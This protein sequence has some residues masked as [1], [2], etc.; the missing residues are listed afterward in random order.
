VRPAAALSAHPVTAPAAAP[1]VVTGLPAAAPVVPRLAV[2][3]VAVPVPPA[4]RVRLGRAGRPVPAAR[5]VPVVPRVLTVSRVLVV[6]RGIHVTPHPGAHRLL[7]RTIHRAMAVLSAPS[8]VTGP[9]GPSVDP[10]RN[11]GRVPA[12]RGQLG[13][14]RPADGQPVPPGPQAVLAPLTVVLPAVVRAGVMTSRSGQ[15]AASARPVPM[16]G[17]LGVRRRPAGLRRPAGRGLP[18]RVPD[19]RVAPGSMRIGPRPR[20]RPR[21]AAIVRLTPSAA[22]ALTVRAGGLAG[23]PALAGRHPARLGRR[24]KAVTAATARLMVAHPTTAPALAP[25]PIVRPGIARPRT[26]PRGMAGRRVRG[27]TAPRRAMGRADPGLVTM[28]V[29]G[30]RAVTG[31]SAAVAGAAVRRGALGRGALGR[32]MARPA[33]AVRGPRAGRTVRAAPPASEERPVPAAR[34]VPEERRV[35]VVTRPTGVTRNGAIHPGVSLAIEVRGWT[36][37]PSLARPCPTRSA[38]TSSTRLPVAS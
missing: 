3:A 32:E 19:A 37:R 2:A 15:T 22:T 8:E 33:V 27:G 34:Q 12:R 10:A 24:G 29:P 13:P 23:R 18:V 6:R 25:R 11:S 16:A 35:P 26:K 17:R 5:L 7:P 1:P 30:R 31:S 21:N 9:S 14:A 20:P 38:L 36:G 28:P 4:G